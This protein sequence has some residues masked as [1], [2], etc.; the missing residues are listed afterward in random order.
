VNLAN[1]F[2]GAFVRASA[3]ALWRL[4]AAR[5]VVGFLLAF[6]LIVGAGVA[7]AETIPATSTPNYPAVSQWTSSAL[8]NQTFS[9]CGAVGAAVVAMPPAQCASNATWTYSCAYT[10]CAETQTSGDISYLRT[11][12][13]TST[14]VR[15]PA[16][17]ATLYLGASRAYTCPS[18]GTVAGT[19]PNKYCSGGTLYTCPENQNYTLSGATCTRPDCT[20]GATRDANG[21]CQNPCG[22]SGATFAGGV[23]VCPG[24]SQDFNSIDKT[25]NCNAARVEGRGTSIAGSGA[26]PSTSCY[27]GC[28]VNHGG[29]SVSMG[30]GST[31]VWSSQIASYTSTK[32]TDVVAAK[33][34]TEDTRTPAQKCLAAGG[35]FI[36]TSSGTVCT[37]AA[38]SPQPITTTKDS[39]AVVKDAA[40][41]VTGTTET[42]TECVGALCTTTTITKDALGAVTG[43][44]VSTA[45]GSGDG[46][47]ED[48]PDECTLFPERV[49]CKE[50]GTPPGDE[51]LETQEKGVASVTVQS[52]ASSSSCPAN[53]ALP[54]GASF[55]WSW[56]CDMATSIRPVLLALAWISSLF[57]VMGAF[58]G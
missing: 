44:T 53:I 48:R 18:G 38:D 29:T 13:Y 41:A 10:A 55:S 47:G 36:T 12:S 11:V 24:F 19:Y 45:A 3:F 8:P 22:S 32:C 23:C 49:G 51:A 1:Q 4:V 52:F 26:E 35:G 56:I 5:P 27:G 16:G 20:G 6:A 14:G 58:V 17:D 34:P 15:Y 39:T 50:L 30:T 42:S 31:A 40:G 9:S 43:S 54:K 21:V 25:C 37:T 57:I 2:I 7:S 33:T 28:V 46:D